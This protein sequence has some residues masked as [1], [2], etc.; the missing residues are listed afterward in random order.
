MND[1]INWAYTQQARRSGPVAK[2]LL[3]EQPGHGPNP[4]SVSSALD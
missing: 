1:L 3:R 2:K 4:L